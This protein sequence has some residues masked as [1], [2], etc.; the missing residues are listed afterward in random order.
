MTE[1]RTEWRLLALPGRGLNLDLNRSTPW[2]GLTSAMSGS[3]YGGPP[4][5]RLLSKI[6][7]V[8]TRTPSSP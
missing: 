6:R 8:P 7:L 1:S 2:I 3:P 4:V 5:C